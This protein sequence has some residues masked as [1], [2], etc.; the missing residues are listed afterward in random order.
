[1]S[2]ARIFYITVS[3]SF[4]LS[5][6][7]T[8]SLQS[9]QITYFNYLNYSSKWYY[10]T[11]FS[12]INGLHGFVHEF[13]YIDGDTIIGSN[14][15][16]KIRNL[17]ISEQVSPVHGITKSNN[18]AYAL[19]ED[20]DSLFIYKYPDDTEKVYSNKPS[21]WRPGSSITYFEGEIPHRVYWMYQSPTRGWVEGIG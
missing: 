10:I 20:A 11:S 3:L 12:G 8:E 2:P 18:Y 15:Y 13:L 19:R 4:I 7:K 17:R 1:M 9:Q 6:V 5:V 14:A 16:Y 21:A